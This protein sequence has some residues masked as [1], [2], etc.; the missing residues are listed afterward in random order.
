M[1]KWPK[2]IPELT[3]E[4]QKIKDDFMKYW[5]EV[6]PQK[7]S[8][9]D[10]FNRIFPVKYCRQRG[11]TLE[12]GAVLGE[13]IPYEDLTQTEYYALEKLPEMAAVIQKR[14]P[15]INVVIGDCQEKLNFPDNYFNRIL[16]VHVLEHLP[17]LP[18]ALK[19]IHRLLKPEGD[20]CVIIPC[21][22]GLAH[23]IAR[24]I[25]AERLFKKRYNLDYNWCIRSEHLNMPAEILEELQKFFKIKKKKFFPLFI[26]SLHLNLAIGMILRPNKSAAAKHL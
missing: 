9:Y 15:Q 12:I 5:H 14:F 17:D 4:Q 1:S 16:A 13:Q 3:K 26:P 24:L 23:R 8:L 7:Y 21:E 19:E 11:K 10:R 18:S 25:S 22:G 20:F 2:K 6:S